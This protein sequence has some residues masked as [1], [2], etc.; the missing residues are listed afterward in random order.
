MKRN[1]N[2]YYVRKPNHFSFYKNV[3]YPSS[4]SSFIVFSFQPQLVLLTPCVNQ[5]SISDDPGG[6][7]MIPGYY[8]IYVEIQTWKKY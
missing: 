1:N 2:L 6:F 8:G 7:R 5:G 3:P 4:Q